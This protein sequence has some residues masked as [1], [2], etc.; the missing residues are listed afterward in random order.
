MAQAN[1]AL[2]AINYKIR[3]VNIPIDLQL[4][5]FDCLITPI[6]LYS[7]KIWSYENIEMIERFHLKF[8]KQI[9]NYVQ[10]HQ[11]TWFT[12]KLEDT[13]WLYVQK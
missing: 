10:Q 2:F 7:T 5:L 3:N 9:L 8:L 13:P 4:K 6:L 1:K 12:E 11:V